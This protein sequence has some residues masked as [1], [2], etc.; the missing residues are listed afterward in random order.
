MQSVLWVQTLLILAGAGFSYYYLSSLDAL[1]AAYGGGVAL[2]S[3]LILIRRTN[4]AMKSVSEGSGQVMALL[5][6]GVVQRYVFVL[7]ALGIGLALLKF[8]AKPMLAV[9]GI[10]QLAYFMSWLGNE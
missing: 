10:A 2:F 8:N 6:I 3:S 9:F 5:Y 7:L 4:K 1:S